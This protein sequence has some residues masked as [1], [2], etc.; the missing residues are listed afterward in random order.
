MELAKSGPH[1]MNEHIYILE[2][3]ALYCA[4]DTDHCKSIH[5]FDGSV[6]DLGRLKKSQKWGSKSQL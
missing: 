2:K 3:Y 5:T 4:G 6:V 1:S